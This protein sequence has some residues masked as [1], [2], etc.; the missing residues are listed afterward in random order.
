[1]EE[2]DQRQSLEDGVGPK[3]GNAEKTRRPGKAGKTGKAGKRG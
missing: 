1:M 3:P 2:K